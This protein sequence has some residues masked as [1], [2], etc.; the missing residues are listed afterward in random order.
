MRFCH[1][2]GTLTFYIFTV[3]VIAG[4]QVEAC[5][6]CSVHSTSLGKRRSVVSFILVRKWIQKLRWGY[7]D[8]IRS[9]EKR[10][11]D[12]VVFLCPLDKLL[13]DFYSVASF[14]VVILYSDRT[15]VLWVFRKLITRLRR[16][17]AFFIVGFSWSHFI[18][19][20]KTT[21]ITLAL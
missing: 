2:S 16:A 7:P 13:G 18:F 4:K 12:L 10:A 9:T 14:S 6:Q 17:I 20:S 15:Y 19:K 8:A 11:G 5:S 21:Y 1:L 3:K